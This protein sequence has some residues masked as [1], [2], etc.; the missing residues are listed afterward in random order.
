MTK[1]ST[2]QS[3]SVMEDDRAATNLGPDE[4]IDDIVDVAPKQP[5]KRFIGRRAAAERAAAKV[6]ENG[7]PL[8]PQAAP[9]AVAGMPICFVSLFSMY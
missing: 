8:E 2:S 7:Q 5:R 1:T 4:G 3:T 6:A 9:G